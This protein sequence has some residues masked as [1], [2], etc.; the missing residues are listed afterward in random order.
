MELACRRIGFRGRSLLCQE[1]LDSSHHQCR[2]FAAKVDRAVK[3][4]L[5]TDVD[6]RTR[7]GR[8]PG[9]IHLGAR[10]LP[11]QLT[12]SI[13]RMLMKFDP[14]QLRRD[15]LS[16][17]ELL[18][19]R[20]PPAKASDIQRRAKSLEREIL[21]RDDVKLSRSKMSEEELLSLSRA[22][23]ARVLPQLRSEFH[24][25]RPVDYTPYMCA[26]YVANRFPED[27]A[28]LTRVFSE[29][30]DRL[31]DFAPTS[32]LDFGSGVATVSFAA[33]AVFPDSLKE[34]YCV[35][36]SP[37]MNNTAKELIDNGT[38]GEEPLLSKAY[39]RQH[40]PASHERKY[41]LVCSA[42]SLLELP[43][44]KDRLTMLRSLWQKT[45]RFLVLVELGNFAGYQLVMEARDHLLGLDKLG[46]K[47]RRREELDT[48]LEEGHV[49][50]PCPHDLVCP[51]QAGAASGGVTCH[52]PVA[53]QPL[54][55][56]TLRNTPR[57]TSRFSY[58]V[59]EKT[60]EQ[61][62]TEE[63]QW[64]RVVESVLKRHHCGICR[65]CCADGHL[66]EVLVTRQK[67]GSSIYQTVRTARWGDRVPLTMVPKTEPE[68]QA[69]REA[70][71]ARTLERT[72]RTTTDSSAASFANAIHEEGWETGEDELDENLE[73]GGKDRISVEDD[74]WQSRY[75]DDDFD[76]KK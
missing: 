24:H 18:I 38:N 28:V 68:L 44:S 33:N 31:P 54:P 67:H 61:R 17:R 50:A 76:G 64:P 70:V 34:Y 62:T 20:K 72:G 22:V 74:G 56:M 35:D 60:D 11:L 51:R 65:V 45:A 69:D 63:Q 6:K 40:F 14:L 1:L 71:V 59:L 30:R 41:D 53:F 75:K 10:D 39:F 58:L 23:E 43:T 47:L 9:N 46:K 29:I 37:D 26:Q 5:D 73:D 8:L 16:F 25:W 21:A 13:N 7:T 52:F 3:W 2:R 42:H 12:M 55:F 4:D 19:N 66:K 36:V 32:L 27:Y 15:A 48:S 57:I 49:F